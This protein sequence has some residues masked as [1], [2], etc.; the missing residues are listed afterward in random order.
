MSSSAGAE[1]WRSAAFACA[2]ACTPG[3]R[4]PTAGG[5]SY[6][7]FT[8]FPNRVRIRRTS[9]RRALCRL[10]EK[11]RVYFAHPSGAAQDSL[12]ASLRATFAHWAHADSWRLREK[13]LRELGLHVDDPAG[14]EEAE[15][16]GADERKS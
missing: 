7:G 13:V 2:C 5:F 14:W 9:V 16:E 6:L 8:L 12:V 3:N 11:S 4:Q 1:I 10:K 15:T